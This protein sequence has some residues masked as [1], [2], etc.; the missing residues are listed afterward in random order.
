MS[1]V[2]SLFLA[3]IKSFIEFCMAHTGTVVFMREYCCIN[4]T[5]WA[6]SVFVC[7]YC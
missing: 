3:D 7:V 2:A 5:V 4:T 6:E 1:I